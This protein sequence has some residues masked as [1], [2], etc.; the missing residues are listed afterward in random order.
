MA[1]VHRGDILRTSVNLVNAF[2][3]LSWVQESVYITLFLFLAYENLDTESTVSESETCRAIYDFLPQ[4][5]DQL[6]ISAGN[7]KN[8]N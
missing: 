2:R 5:D 3:A 6:A 4:Q 7:Q 1:R 8:N